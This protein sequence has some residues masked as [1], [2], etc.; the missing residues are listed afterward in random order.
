MM[1]LSSSDMSYAFT[2]QRSGQACKVVRVDK[3]RMCELKK[4]QTCNRALKNN[5]L[6]FRITLVLVSGKLNYRIEQN[7]VK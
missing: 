4:P 6:N 7:K 1:P 2:S 5:T 3:V